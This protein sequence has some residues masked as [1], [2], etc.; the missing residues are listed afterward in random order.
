M[1]LVDTV[2]LRYHLSV[3]IDSRDYIARQQH[4]NHR[5]KVEHLI[6]S[7]YALREVPLQTQPK[8][9]SQPQPAVDL[10]SLLFCR[11]FDH[12]CFFVVEGSHG[13]QSLGLFAL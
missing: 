4:R 9:K 1:V 10:D 7:D 8:T 13:Q 2:E 3:C 11:F 12:F 6:C 5:H